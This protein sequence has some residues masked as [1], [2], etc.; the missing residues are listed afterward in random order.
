MSSGYS[1]LVAAPEIWLWRARDKRKGGKSGDKNGGF[2]FY[3]VG[4]GATDYYL[5]GEKAEIRG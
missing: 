4:Q 2:G 5:L 1:S 3:P